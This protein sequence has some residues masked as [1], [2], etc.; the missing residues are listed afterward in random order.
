MKPHPFVDQ[1]I[2]LWSIQENLLQWYRAIFITSESIFFTFA[3]TLSANSNYLFSLVLAVLG[4]GYV[5]LWYVV[6]NSRGRDVTF[7]QWVT[8]KAEGTLSKKQLASLSEGVVTTFKKYQDGEEDKENL[9]NRINK[10][11]FAG[12]LVTDDTDFKHM[13]GSPTRKRMDRWLPTIFGV[14]WILFSIYGFW[15]ILCP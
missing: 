11:K 4:F 5:I 10:G 15:N 2:A 9:N 7:V 8:K 1:L 3:I 13:L 14:I 6:C 12:E